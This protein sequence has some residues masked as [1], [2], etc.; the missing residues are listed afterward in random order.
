M[1]K[2]VTTLC[3]LKNSQFYIPSSGRCTVLYSKPL[4][5]PATEITEGEL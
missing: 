4:G 5:R 2:Y 3:A 1:C